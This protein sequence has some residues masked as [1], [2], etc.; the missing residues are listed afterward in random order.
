L[1]RQRLVEIDDNAEAVALKGGDA[2]SVIEVELGVEDGVEAVAV[3][4]GIGVGA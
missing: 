4:L 1:R 3:R 2:D